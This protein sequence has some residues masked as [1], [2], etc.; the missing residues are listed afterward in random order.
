MYFEFEFSRQK[1][2]KKHFLD[3]Y[4]NVNYTLTE[5]PTFAYLREAS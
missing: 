4:V 2:L 3:D 5:F 1:L